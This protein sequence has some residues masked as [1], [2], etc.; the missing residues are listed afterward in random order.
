MFKD[1][2]FFVIFSPLFIFAY[3]LVGLVVCYIADMWCDIYDDLEMDNETVI[4]LAVI[5][6]PISFAAILLKVVITI[7]VFFKHVYISIIKMII[8]DWKNG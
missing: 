5:L 6:W 7:A 4:I 8:E 3:A 1:I 2:E